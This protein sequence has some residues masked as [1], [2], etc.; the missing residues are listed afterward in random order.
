MLACYRYIELNPVRAKMVDGPGEYPWSSY[1]INAL[2]LESDLCSPHETYQALGRNP[3]KR[4]QAY[5]ALFRYHVDSEFLESIRAATNRGLAVGSEHFKDE[6]ET[7]CNRSV[8][9][10]PVGRPKVAR[11]R[12]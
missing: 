9:A 7:L 11:N 10:N 4:Q 8:R 12:S 1:Q 2:G 6:I 3:I 5:Q